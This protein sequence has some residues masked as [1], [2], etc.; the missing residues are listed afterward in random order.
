MPSS[1][2]L[3]PH[4]AHPLLQRAY[5]GEAQYFT[6]IASFTQVTTNLKSGCSIEEIR[7]RGNP[8]LCLR[9]H[10]WETVRSTEL[11]IQLVFLL[12]L[13]TASQSPAGP[14][15]VFFWS[16]SLSLNQ[17]EAAFSTSPSPSI[18]HVLV[19]AHGSLVGLPAVFH[20]VPRMWL[21]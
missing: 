15:G 4:D 20:T 21:Y 10:S 16:D 12:P 17:P 8:I 7:T 14:L 13:L 18:N 5:I 2:Q 11:Q 9:S 3:S 6:S 19:P 1:E